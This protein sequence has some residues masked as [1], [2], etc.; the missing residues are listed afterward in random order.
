MNPFRFAL[1]RGAMLSLFSIL[2]LMLAACSGGDD[3]GATPAATGGDDLGGGTIAV[4]DGGVD[5]SAD[6]L[7]FDANVIQATA[8]EAFTVRFTN[9]DTVP[10]NWSI[11][12]EEGGE[13]IAVGNII[14]EGEVDEISVPELEPGEYFF[15][16]DVHPVEMTGTVVVEG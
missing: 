6:D 3:G 2:A 7:A 12:T 9:N 14:S 5:I 10:H 13:P 11:Y 16:C 8:G 4:T 1:R 15:V